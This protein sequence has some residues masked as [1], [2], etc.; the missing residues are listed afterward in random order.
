MIVSGE[1]SAESKVRSRRNYNR[2]AFFNGLSYMC[3]GD[4]VIIL[5]A[6][7]LG[8]P[9][10]VIVLL[11]S[12]VYL[13][14]VLL[15][16]GRTVTARVGAARSQASFWVMRNLAALLVASASIFTALG[17]PAGAMAVLL[18]G[19]FLFYGF[20]AAG[21]VMGQ[22]LCGDITDSGNR[23][24]FIAANTG[25]FNGASLVAIVVIS[26]ILRLSDSVWALT[27]IIVC[28]AGVGVFSSRFINR[29]EETVKIRDSARAP[30]LGEIGQL[31][32][33]GA[34]RAQMLAG[35]M[36][37][38]GIIMTFPMSTLILKRGFGISDTGALVFAMAQLATALVISQIS[39]NLADRFGPRRVIGGAYW[40]LA[41]ICLLWFFS[42]AE[43]SWPYLTLPFIFAG[44]AAVCMNNSMSHY[45][46]QAVPERNRVSASMFSSVITGAAAGIIGALISSGLLKTAFWF[47]GDGQ[48]LAGYRVYFVL[49]GLLITA[50]STLIA[51]LHRLPDEP[52]LR[53]SGRAIP[54]A[55]R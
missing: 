8:L 54:R 48:P 13:G 34:F 40:L 27:G 51:R 3:L 50:G 30:I 45:F 44:L 41:G 19:A 38:I 6:V 28:G 25:L 26:Q 12:M 46:L 29:V 24:R 7:R 52:L 2:F 36:I 20:R 5:F 9:D 55:G 35:L 37:N 18:A 14:F 11:G 53:R 31:L 42:P 43:L 33:L 39:A 15:P 22:P 17:K 1:L 16:L 21:V 32:G 23:A 4:T 10:Y 47:N 49:A